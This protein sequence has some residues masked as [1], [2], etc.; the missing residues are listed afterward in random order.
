MLLLALFALSTTLSW[1]VPS[2]LY[3]ATRGSLQFSINDD[4][5]LY[6]LDS[7]GYVKYVYDD[8][9]NIISGSVYQIIEE[10]NDG[11]YYSFRLRHKY[12][13][14]IYPGYSG[15]RYNGGNVEIETSLAPSRTF[16]LQ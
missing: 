16:I 2:G 14:N 15:W 10:R 5:Y 12:T 9:G 4:G 7:N 1:A 13:G 8:N 6:M 3:K 11:D